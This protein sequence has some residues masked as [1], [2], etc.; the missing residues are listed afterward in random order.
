MKYWLVL[1]T[2]IDIEIMMPSIPGGINLA[3]IIKVGIVVKSLS[4]IEAK[5]PV[6]TYK[7]VSSQGSNGTG[8][9]A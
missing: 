8:L 2:V 9:S 1:I 7:Q 4:K 3:M 6:S 5:V